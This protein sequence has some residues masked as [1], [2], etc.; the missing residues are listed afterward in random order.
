[1][2]R[3]IIFIALAI[4]GSFKLSAFGA[5]EQ[6]KWQMLDLGGSIRSSPNYRIIDSCFWGAVEKS[7][8]ANYS[9]QSGYIN[10]SLSVSLGTKYSIKGYVRS[11]TG[12]GLSG[13]SLILSGDG[14][15]SYDT[16]S[17]GYYEFT[18]L[19]SG[20]YI[21]TPSKTGYAF[22]PQRRI[23]S[24]LN[25]DF[26]G[27]DFT[28]AQVGIT[29]KE[30]KI[31]RSLF[32]PK[33]GQ[34]ADIFYKLSTD[35]SVTIKIYDIAGHL[36]KTIAD[37]ESKKAGFNKDEWDGKDNSGSIV[38]PG[39]YFMYIKSKSLNMTKKIGVRR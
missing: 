13:V 22:E 7:L 24:S 29:E 38:P 8:S 19:S 31:G 36:V 23:Y 32:D 21:I 11:S 15:G 35:E 14:A 34:S 37:N 6:I 9:L 3:K 30:V 28:G 33:T 27:Q 1:M 25:A 4:L 5:G 20:D 26:S 10:K 2:M 16:G 18:N 39:L 17:T 12:S